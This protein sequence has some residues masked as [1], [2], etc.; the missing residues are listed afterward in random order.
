LEFPSVF[1]GSL[2]RL[3]APRPDD[4]DHFAGWSEDDVYLRS[5]DN[6]PARPLSPDGYAEWER[7]FL[8]APNSFLFRLRTLEDDLLIGIAALGDLQWNHRTAMLGLAIGHP[9]YRGR[10]YGSDAVRLLLRY[11]FRELDLYRVWLHTLGYNR[12]A[13]RCFERAGF[14]PEGVGRSAIQRE[15]QRFDLLYY[16]LLRDEWE[17]LQR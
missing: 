17:V 15:G 12:R 3:A 6:D 14:R 8:S 2:L 10:G 5:F 4:A 9:E 1:R 11:A 13:Q 7:P 16:G